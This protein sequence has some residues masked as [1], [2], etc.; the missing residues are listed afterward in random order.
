MTTQE[1]FDVI[2]SDPIHPWVK[3]AAALYSREYFELCKKRLNEHGVVTQ[4]VPLYESNEAAVKSQIA[5]FFEAFPDGTIWSNDY[6]GAGYDV[7]VLG[8]NEPTK[9][10][11][12]AMQTRLDRDDHFLVRYSLLEINL[13]SAADL[14]TTYAG[15]AADLQAWLADAQINQDRSLR[16][17]Y[18]AGMGLNSYDSEYIFNR[19]V[20]YRKFPEG[21]FFDNATQDGSVQQL[22]Q[23]RPAADK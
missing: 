9:I 21:L 18:L 19:I 5:T 11:L 23:I 14:M 17:Q 2:T 1:K 10:D 3:G 8:Q 12:S 7:I 15:R 22:G 6:L 13:G 16:L 4:W 20:E